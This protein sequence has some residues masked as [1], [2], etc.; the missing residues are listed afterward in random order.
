MDVYEGTFITLDAE[1]ACAFLYNIRLIQGRAIRPYEAFMVTGLFK[2]NLYA[3]KTEMEK[4]YK[5]THKKI[6]TKHKEVVDE[7]C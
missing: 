5:K 1:Y 6:A 7:K 4:Q 3:T 2:L